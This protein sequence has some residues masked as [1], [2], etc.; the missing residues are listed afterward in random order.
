MSLS[1]FA[2]VPFTIDRASETNENPMETPKPE[3]V[4]RM[5]V[6]HIREVS[7]TVRKQKWVWK[8]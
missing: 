6:D 3:E 8:S 1:G 4:A 5:F 2:S 7:Y